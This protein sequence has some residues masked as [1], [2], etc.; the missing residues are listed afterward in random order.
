[1]KMSC[2]RVFNISWETMM[3]ATLFEVLVCTGYTISEELHEM[4][5]NNYKVP[6]HDLDAVKLVSRSQN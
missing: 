6:E 5:F 2:L 1:M 3:L 4:S